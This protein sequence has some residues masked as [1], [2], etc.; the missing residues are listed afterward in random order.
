VGSQ[1]LSAFY[2]FLIMTFGTLIM[3]FISTLA[4]NINETQPKHLRTDESKE[5][6]VK[7]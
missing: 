1:N 6:K 3:A 2:F 4:S 7:G 5:I